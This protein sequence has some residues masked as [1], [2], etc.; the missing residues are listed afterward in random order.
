MPTDELQALR[1][2]VA[3]LERQVSLPAPEL[4]LYHQF[5]Q[6]A[7][8]GLAIAGPDGTLGVVNPA[9]ARMHG[10]A[11]EQL[12]GT[13]VAG[14]SAPEEI[15]LLAEAERCADETGHHHWE[16]VHVRRDGSRFPAAIDLS[17]IR[18]DSGEVIYRVASIRDITARRHTEAALRASEALSRALIDNLPGGAAFIVDR[19]LRYQLAGG[20]A[21]QAASLA[22]E[23]ILGRRVQDVLPPDLAR[24]HEPN[25]RRALNGEPF[26]V[27]H[28]AHGR[29]F[30][31]RGTPLRDETGDVF[32]ALAVSYDITERR[33]IEDA[34]RASEARYRMLFESIDEGFC[35]IQLLFDEH[36]RPVDYRFIEINRVFEQQ[37]GLINAAGRNVRELVPDLETHWFEIYGRV[38]LTGEPTRFVSHSQ[39]MGRWFDVYAFRIGEPGERQVAVL[40]NDITDRKRREANQKFL[41]E[42][43]EDFSRWPEAGEIMGAVGAKVGAHLGIGSCTLFEIDEAADRMAIGYT[44]NRSGAPP[45]PAEMPVAALF[46]QDFR[47]AARAGET[48][49]VRDTQADPRTVAGAHAARGVLALIA[50]AFQTGGAWKFL[51]TVT[52]SRPREWRADEVELF[53][54]VAN[55]LV[56]RLERAR[57]E[58]A[59]RRSEQRLQQVF[60]QAPVAICVLRGPD[61]LF[62]L[63]NQPFQSLVQRRDLVGH[64][65]GDV[66]PELN[67][68]VWS[69]FERVLKSGQPFAANDFYIPYDQDGDGAIEDHWFNVVYHPLLEADGSVSGIVAVCS[70]V[71]VHVT[72]R[73]ELQRVNRELE[74]FAYAAS[75][76]LQEPLRM[77]N[78]YTE[79]I[80]RRLA[81]DDPKMNQFAAFVHQGVGRMHALIQD[82]L[83]YS[84]TVQRDD[85]P[86]GVADLQTALSEAISVLQNRIEEQS[87]VVDCD[88][89]P[90]VRGETSQLAHVF[91]NLLSN[92]LKYRKPDLPPRVRVSASQRD[93]SWVIAVEDNGIG[94]DQRYAERIFGLF[95][96]LHKDEYP[97]TGLGLAICKRIVER[98]GGAM[99]AEGRPGDGATFFF[100]LARADAD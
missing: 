11:P 41:A 2:R 36:L 3:E 59:R 67:A 53:Q 5:F 54:E 40:F 20:E 64:R 58:E 26:H 1:R 57:A 99:W 75:H 29:V 77:V 68:D 66:L 19:D 10:Y 39:P 79:Q 27:E 72:A 55:R 86:V 76:D 13:R 96:R 80:L 60:T 17:V 28:T 63:A 88:P 74:E 9:F 94:F 44:W 83:S 47:Q 15:A 62:E 33:Q 61:L 69:A 12:A 42:L 7:A 93:H 71:T 21:L 50:V 4:Q 95:K 97:G 92:A 52:D 48:I 90:S 51:L 45:E 34:A 100:S 18:R 56:P 89:L 78:I 87:A 85:A 49:V 98:Y 16:S 81:T 37:T 46:G 6:H 25:Y 22:H 32:A 23:A 84:R 35:I 70:E 65:L 91:Q 73:Q 8:V 43:S 30:L 24:E 38:A 31:S 14:L 82:L